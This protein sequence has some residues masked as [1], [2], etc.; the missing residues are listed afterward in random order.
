MTILKDMALGHSVGTLSAARRGRCQ[1]RAWELSEGVALV[2]LCIC[3]PL[4]QA[5]PCIYRRYLKNSK[6]WC[7]PGFSRP[8]ETLLVCSQEAPEGGRRGGA[9]AAG[10][11]ICG[12]KSPWHADSW[13][14]VASA[15][16]RALH[17]TAVPRRRAEPGDRA[18][19]FTSLS[20]FELS[21]NGR[22]I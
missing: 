7:C 4:L 13:L 20:T 16:T 2:F 5:V 9:S 8:C 12:G 1:A 11:F 17:Q 3:D 6:P 22:E 19:Q 15:V 18:F 21:P 14:G 10:S